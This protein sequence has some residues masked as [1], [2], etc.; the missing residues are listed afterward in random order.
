M[1]TKYRAGTDISGREH[2]LMPVTV[3]ETVCRLFGLR[4][5]KCAAPFAL[6]TTHTRGSNQQ[7]AQQILV[8][9]TTSKDRGHTIHV[10]FDLCCSKPTRRIRS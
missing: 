8:S 6:G 7:C 3:M 5:R 2:F 9:E 1:E 10:Y 4:S